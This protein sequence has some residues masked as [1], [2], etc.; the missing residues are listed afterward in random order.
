M[1]Q[2]C[3]RIQPTVAGFKCFKMHRRRNYGGFE[4]YNVNYN[5]GG[6]SF[7]R[8]TYEG[9]GS[10]GRRCHEMLKREQIKKASRLKNLREA[11]NFHK[12]KSRLKKE[13]SPAY[14]HHYINEKKEAY[15]EVQRPR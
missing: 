3:V 2:N 9:S 14:L 7:R 5:Y 13:F 4:G 11:L 10:N 8:N 1:V 15:H 6:Y 12:L